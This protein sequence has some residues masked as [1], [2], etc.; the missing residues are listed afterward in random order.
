MKSVVHLLKEFK[1]LYSMSTKSSRRGC[2]YL[3]CVLMMYTSV[4]E[5]LPKPEAVLESRNPFNSP[6]Q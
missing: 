5:R 4:T 2:E 1:F 6:E 3:L